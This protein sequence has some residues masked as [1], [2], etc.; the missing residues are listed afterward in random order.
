MC[1]A[2]LI[3][4]TQRFERCMTCTCCLQISI[5]GFW[6][7]IYLAKKLDHN[8]VSYRMYTQYLALGWWL[9]GPSHFV[10]PRV[11]YPFHWDHGVAS[12]KY[13]IGPLSYDYEPLWFCVVGYER[14]PSW[15]ALAPLLSPTAT[16][17]W[18]C[19]NEQ[20]KVWNRK[21]HIKSSMQ[22]EDNKCP[23][24][25]LSVIVLYRTVLF[26]GDFFDWSDLHLYSGTNA[27]SCV[28]LA[29]STAVI[30]TKWTRRSVLQY[31]SCC[32]C[33]LSWWK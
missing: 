6:C 15:W 28:C 21:P 33:T 23:Q 16:T 12:C 27:D 20:V 9:K 32:I 26:E 17:V 25:P 31:H 2:L 3:V 8:I 5:T 10:G 1:T 22:L 4:S 7:Q 24:C 19:V 13:L 18:M 30:S 29:N 11:G 14:L